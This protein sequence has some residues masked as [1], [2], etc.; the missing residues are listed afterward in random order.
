MMRRCL[1]FVPALWLCA[2]L[3]WAAAGRPTLAIVCQIGALAS[4]AVLLVTGR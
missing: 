2:A 3:A 4:L 1:L